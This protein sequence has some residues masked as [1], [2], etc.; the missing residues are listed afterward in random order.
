MIKRPI[1]IIFFLLAFPVFFFA[2]N[3]P[4]NKQGLEDECTIGV[5]MGN[6]TADG[7]PF[8]W[9]NRDGS[10]RHFVWYVNPSGTDHGYLAMGNSEG[11]KMGVNDAG[12]SLQNASCSNV[13]SSGY[14]YANNTALKA[15]MLSKTGSV[16]EV[17]QHI[18]D[19]TTKKANYWGPPKI[20]VGFSDAKG[21]ASMFEI[22]DTV[23]YEYDPT[24]STRL[25][26]YSQQVVARANSAHL[27]S[28]QK[29]DSTT[30]G[31]RYTTARSDLIYYTDH[32]GLT[33]ANWIKNVSRH[34]QPGVDDMPSR[35]D[36]HAVMLVHGVNNGEDPRIV[37][38]WLGLGNP[39]YTIPIPAWV[40][41]QGNLSS[42]VTSSGTDDSIAGMSEKLYAKKD[43]NNYDQYINSL[44]APVEDNI[45][46]V[47]EF[48]RQRWFSSGFSLNEAVNIHQEAAETAWQTMRI[49]SQG[50]GRNL[51]KPP[52]INSVNTSG[53]GQTLTFSCSAS[54]DDGTIASFNWDFGDGSGSSSSAPSHTYGSNGTYLVRCRVVDDKGARNSKWKYISVGGGTCQPGSKQGDANGDC[55]VDGFDYVTWWQ[56]FNSDK[57]GPQ[58]G[59]FNNSGKVDGFDYVIW[60][61]NF[62]R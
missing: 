23:F 11:L 21:K 9:K 27:N 44:F 37:T 39:D 61:Q 48:A 36:T 1:I 59:D 49:M 19:D 22:G 55:K 28:D 5:A 14:V 58:F 18:I 20:C 17:R 47:V 56:N 29:D 50:S 8:S 31:N 41:L 43:T 51:N 57:T 15:H 24:N 7:R 62:G 33:A 40:A 4:G 34:G 25:Q 26:Q 13:P 2:R 53:S 42:R 38:A 45:F 32:G 54:D 35:S 10:G 12:V 60:W 52:K 46:E 16:S 30:G 6:A 3:T